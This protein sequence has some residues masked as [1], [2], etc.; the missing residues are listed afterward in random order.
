MDNEA[1]SNIIVGDFWTAG[2]LPVDIVRANAEEKCEKLLCIGKDK[3]G[4][5]FYSCSFSDGAEMLWMIEQFK[6][7]LLSGKF[8]T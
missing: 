1:K 2:D 5:A 6:T 3:S 8:G 7:K 4:K